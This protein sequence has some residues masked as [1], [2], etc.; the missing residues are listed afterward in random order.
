M[1]TSKLLLPFAVVAIIAATGATADS[2]TSRTSRT[3]APATITPDASAP[4]GSRRV[5]DRIAMAEDGRLHLFLQMSDTPAALVFADRSESYYRDTRFLFRG[6]DAE[7]RHAAEE[8]AS[9]ESISHAYTLDQRQQN[10]VARLTSPEFGATIVYRTQIAT[11]GIAVLARADQWDALSR[12]PGVKNVALIRPKALRVNSSINYMGTRNFWDPARLN[13]RGENTGIAIIDTGLDFVHR[14]FGGSGDGSPTGTGT[15]SFVRNATTIGGSTPAT[16]FPTAKVVWGWDLVGDA[17]NGG[18]ANPPVTT[19]SPDPNPMDVNGHGT[20]C[21]SLAAGFGTTSANLTYTGPWD[22]TNPD[23]AAAT[24]KVSPGIAPLAALYGLR[25]FGIGGATFVSADAVDIATAVRIWQLGP[26]GAPLPPRLASLN[27]AAAVPRTP[28]LSVVSM[29]LGD[30]AGLD[31]PGDP[32]TDSANAA[33]AAGM[34]VLAAAGNAYD[35]YYNAGTP[36]NVT[37][38][39]SVAASLNGQ[40]ITVADAMASYSSR[41]PRPSD[42]HL[43]PDITGPA[44]AVST[45]S[46]GTNNGNRSFNGTSSATPHVAG[47]MALLHQLRPGYTGEEYKALLMNSVRIEPRVSAAGAFYGLSRVGVGRVTL[48]PLDN[49]PTALVMST[50][51]DAPVSVSFGLVSVPVASSQQLTKTVRV[52]N[53]ENFARTFAVSF[54]NWATTPG[55]T[56]SLPDGPTVTVPANGETTL[57]VQLDVVGNQL[58]HSRDTQASATQGTNVA[59][60]FISEAAGRLHLSEIDGPGHSMRLSVHSVVRPNSALSVTPATLN[61][62]PAQTFTLTGTGMDTGP[63][64][65]TLTNNPADIVSHAKA[66]ELQH[67]NATSSGT[68]FEQSEIKYVGVTSDY[69]RRLLPFDPTVGTTNQSTVLVFAVAMHKDYA[70]PGELGTQVRILIDRNRTGATNIVL[71]NYTSN[72]STNQNVYFTGTSATAGNVSDGTTVTSTTFFANITTAAANNMLNNN[73]AMLPV[74]AQQ[75]GLTAATARFNYKVQ[76]TRHDYLGYTVHSESPWLTYDVANPGIDA[77]ANAGVNEPFVLNAQP[78]QTFTAAVN[79]AN[80]Q[81]NSSQ[82]LLMVYPHNATGDRTQVISTAAPLALTEAVSRKTHGSAGDFDIPLPGVECRSS[83]GNHSI[84]V[85][86]NNPVVSGS[87][88]VASGTGS[89]AGSPTFS[90]N[91]MTVNL[92]NVA[93]AQNLTIT[94]E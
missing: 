3:A 25:V 82:G 75:L 8:R 65:N 50:E 56:Y 94:L 77:S 84:V 17:Y 68:I 59:R 21:A 35:N 34:S 11:N 47:A 57:R 91:T 78:G 19:P 86:F 76:V 42:S 12:L 70:I 20:A 44:E 1:K 15:T 51:P 54:M 29:S 49:F 52:V 2:K 13:G 55:A 66:F 85:S 40:G 22:A 73:I 39:I 28:V 63:N 4:A 79:P 14:S 64:T 53:K 46:V 24:T 83:G 43:K 58:R 18:F 27:G 61:S 93:N 90:G 36:A 37:S 87:A 23:T 67:Q 71:R 69:A 88:S 72:T 30:D 89:V 74:R 62:D 92:T 32:D 31:Y 33:T 10:L 81:S 6:G 16:N 9:T 38:A 26:E 48:N 7:A 41:G 45:A 5:D 60:N 80:I